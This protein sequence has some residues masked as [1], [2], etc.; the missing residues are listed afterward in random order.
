MPGSVNPAVSIG[1]LPH[2]VSTKFTEAHGIPMSINEY[3]D[4]ASQRTALASEGRRTWKL[5]KRLDVVNLALLRSFWESAKGGAFY[6]YNPPETIPPYTPTP[7]GTA[8]QY[9]VR[10]NNDWSQTNSM[11]RIDTE[12]ELVEIASTTTP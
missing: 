10:F 3:H 2:S 6:F 7:S 1:T 4:G 12:I 5:S 9:L 8:G 11:A